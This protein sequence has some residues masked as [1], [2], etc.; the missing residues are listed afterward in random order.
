MKYEEI[1]V[2]LNRYWEGETT[3]EEERKIKTYFQSG[4]IDERLLPFVPMF[5]ALREEKMVQLA[6]KGKTA[7]LR[8]KMYQWAVA[9]SVA[10]LI[11][12]AWW[13]LR[14]GEPYNP[15]VAQ[16]PIEM[17]NDLDKQ[18]PDTN[19]NTLVAEKVVEKP[20][21]AKQFAPKS[22]NILKRPLAKKIDPEAAQAMAEIKAALALVSGKLDKGRNQAVKGA[23][24]L[25]ALG[26]V[27]KRTDG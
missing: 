1:H 8:P 19:Q 5:Q 2:L 18:T 3:L 15:E 7:A 6:S 22:K 20:V 27:P 21:A 14:D 25:E 26:K 24:H 16:T 11:G 23:T 17:P 9:A 4:A 13:V 12:A 10:L